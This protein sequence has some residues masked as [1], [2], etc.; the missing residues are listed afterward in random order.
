M[1]VKDIMTPDVKCVPLSM[2]LEEAAKMMARMDCGFL[3]IT[4]DDDKNLI[5]VVTD[6]DIVVR[7]IA[8]GVSP[9]DTTIG[10]VRSNATYCCL[11]NDDIEAAAETMRHQCVYRL[12]VLNNEKDR[13]LCGVIS[14]GDI[15]RHQQETLAGKVASRITA[16]AA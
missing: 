14:L 12:L 3:P 13:Q 5:G 10:D 1:L 6:R 7:G 4:E 11:E 9:R 16:G 2:T 8:A 15:S